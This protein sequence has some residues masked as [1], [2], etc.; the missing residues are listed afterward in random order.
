MGHLFDKKIYEKVVENK[1]TLPYVFETLKHEVRHV[2]LDEQEHV[3]EFSVLL[4]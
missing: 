1:D 3:T 2:V 4:G